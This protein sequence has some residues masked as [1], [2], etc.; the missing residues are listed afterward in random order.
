MEE[1]SSGMVRGRR[2]SGRKGKE[3]VALASVGLVASALGNIIQAADRGKLHR[4]KRYLLSVIDEWQA[5]HARSRLRI[6]QLEEEVEGHRVRIRLLEDQ[7]REAEGRLALAL[8]DGREAQAEILRLGG[9]R[10]P[11]GGEGAGR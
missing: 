8:V 7:L 11:G 4:E 1:E 2:K 10:G 5:G 3:P 9:G 6:R